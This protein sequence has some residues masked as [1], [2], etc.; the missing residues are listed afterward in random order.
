ML[1]WVITRIRIESMGMGG[2]S[3]ISHLPRGSSGLFI[4]AAPGRGWGAGREPGWRP[5]RS[6][7]HAPQPHQK[8]SEERVQRGRSIRTHIHTHIHISTQ[9]SSEARTSS[10]SAVAED[11]LAVSILGRIACSSWGPMGARS[12]GCVISPPRSAVALQQCARKRMDVPADRRLVHPTK[13]VGPLAVEDTG[14]LAT[15]GWWRWRNS[16]ACMDRTQPA[17]WPPS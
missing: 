3:D 4:P 16:R 2:V 12:G 14:E 11:R 15:D 8:G 5:K 7:P 9:R 13:T 17:Y 6:A 10:K 1:G